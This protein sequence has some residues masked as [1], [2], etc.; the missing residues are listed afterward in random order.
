MSKQYHGFNPTPQQYKV[1][2]EVLEGD[3]KYIITV[4]PRQAGKTMLAINMML[5]FAI[6]DKKTTT[7]FISPI[8]SQARKVM[9]E[10]YEAIK[11]SDIIERVNFSNFE[12]KLK[13]G[14][15]ILF[16]SAEREDGL[17]GYTFDYLLIDEASYI[18]ESAYKRAIQPTVFIKGKKVLLFSTPRGRDWFYNMHKMGEDPGFPQYSSCRMSYEGN[19]YVNMEEIESARRALPEA[20][21]RAEYLGEFL[22]GESMVFQNF[23]N[24]NLT[25]YPKPVGK[26]Y[27]GLD[28]G[29]ASDFT[30]ATFIDSTGQIVDIY[31]DN[32]KTYETM[33]NAVLTRVKKWNATL[34]VETNSIGGPVFESLKKQ[35]QDT[36]PFN[37][38]N[39][40][41]REIIESLILAFN[42]DT[43]RIPSIELSPDLHHELEVF[44]MTYNPKGRTVQ[45]AARSPFHD[46]MVMS[47]A[48]ANYN[49]LQNKSYGQYVTQGSQRGSSTT[50]YM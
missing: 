17:R 44:E 21:F 13:T 42:E 41:K 11:D 15:K 9:E 31:R 47:L 4:S 46:D 8:Y 27:A 29:Q 38:S 43:I 37:T 18:K 45:Y 5:Y 39:S 16:K 14:S 28:T 35:W 25:R 50:K 10:M 20:I 2:K 48:I 34:L 7:C 33:T 49:R 40:S 32:Q 24:N 23:A 6:N 26:V 3:S 19:P 1:I 36:H 22:E 30:V 12:I